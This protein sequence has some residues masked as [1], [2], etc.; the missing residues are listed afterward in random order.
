MKFSNVFLIFTI[1]ILAFAYRLLPNVPNFSPVLATFLFIGVA[2][3]SKWKSFFVVFSLFYLSDFILNNTVL[4]I[5]YPDK[6]GIIWFSNYMIFTA[7]SYIIIYILGKAFGNKNS[8]FNILN[9]SIVSSILF[10]VLTNT[11]SWIF[12]PFG[13]YPNTIS[14]LFASIVAGIPFFQT[15]LLAD[16][17]FVSFFFFIYHGARLIIPQLSYEKK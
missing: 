9:L 15:S 10:F 11:G 3:K 16:L 13:L 12:D 14:G 4:S 5:Y 1:A 6:E 17:C 8:I 2:S 7:L